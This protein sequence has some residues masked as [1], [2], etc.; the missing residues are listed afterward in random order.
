MSFQRGTI[1]NKAK[2]LVESKRLFE[3][4]APEHDVIDPVQ[5]PHG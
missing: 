5:Y 3:V 1:N 2:G 4:F